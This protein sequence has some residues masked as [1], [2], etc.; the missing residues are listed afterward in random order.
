VDVSKLNFEPT[1]A[2]DEDGYEYDAQ[3]HGCR[4]SGLSHVPNRQE[5]RGKK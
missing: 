1:D 2:K 3:D 4:P 5:L